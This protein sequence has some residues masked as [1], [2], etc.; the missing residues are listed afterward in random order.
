MSV[1]RLDEER[2]GGGRVEKVGGRFPWSDPEQPD[3]LLRQRMRRA[4][5]RRE[6]RERRQAVHFGRYLLVCLA[7]AVVVL[8]VLSRYGAFTGSN[9]PGRAAGSPAVLRTAERLV[10]PEG[11]LVAGV[12]GAD[13]RVLQLALSAAGVPDGPADG[14]F[15]ARTAA[16]VA[17]FQRQAGL[18]ATGVY[19]PS[20]RAALQKALRS[21]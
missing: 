16:A 1:F 17:A 15:G 7:A 2:D 5:K 14:V 3:E 20:T 18:P 6:W 12:V 11:T 19:G 10:L 8:Y 4:R 13:V 21:G 9:S